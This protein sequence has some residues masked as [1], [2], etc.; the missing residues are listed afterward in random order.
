M[1]PLLAWMERHAGKLLIAAAIALF[2]RVVIPLLSLG[3][4]FYLPFSLD[5]PLLV[6]LTEVKT[7]SQIVFYAG[8]VG[9]IVGYIL[10][11]N[12]RGQ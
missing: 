9:G 12:R 1:T 8:L 4:A 7:A 10:R 6:I 2:I 3:Y 11:R 5:Y